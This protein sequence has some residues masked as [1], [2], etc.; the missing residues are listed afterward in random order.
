MSDKLQATAALHLYP[1]DRWWG[2]GLKLRP[3]FD[4]VTK[5]KNYLPCREWNPCPPARSQVTLL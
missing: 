4:A 1:V 3:C 5:R 2:G